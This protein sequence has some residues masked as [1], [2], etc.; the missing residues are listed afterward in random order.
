MHCCYNLDIDNYNN[1]NAI[2]ADLE[3]LKKKSPADYRAPW[4]L[5]YHYCLSA[6]N[7]KAIAEYDY[8]FD[9]LLKNEIPLDLYKD[10]IE[11]L[12]L[13]LMFEKCKRHID[14][15]AEQLKLTDKSRIIS[16]YETLETQL[17]NPPFFVDIK[18]SQLFT[19]LNREDGPGLL[20]RLFGIW[21]PVKEKWEISFINDVKNR[22]Q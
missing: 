9:K 17:L 1:N 13:N 16:Y 2:I 4:L 5:A 8:I 11:A 15:I 22:N 6:Q 19:Y 10:Y 21:A 7:Y 14:I 3:N 18:D 12:Y 20:C